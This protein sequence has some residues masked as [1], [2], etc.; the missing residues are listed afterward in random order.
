MEF[1]TGVNK[2]NS[3][4]LRGFSNML[5]PN[6]DNVTINTPHTDVNNVVKPDAF[7]KSLL[8][9]SGG[10]ASTQK[11]KPVI[12]G[13]GVKPVMSG[14]GVKPVPTGNNAIKVDVSE[15]PRK[16]K[17]WKKNNTPILINTPSLRNQQASVKVPRASIKQ[18]KM[19]RTQNTA[20]PRE[21]IH[22]KIKEELAPARKTIMEKSTIGHKIDTTPNVSE[23][24]LMSGLAD[25]KFAQMFLGSST[26]PNVVKTKRVQQNNMTPGYMT[27]SP[28]QAPPQMDNNPM[29]TGV[30]N[31]LKKLNNIL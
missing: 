28:N 8:S 25:N 3:L 1:N 20:A 5:A 24:K 15:S 19:K 21:V 9:T 6:G 16:L 26:R 10:T 2:Q 14:K 31:N 22:R 7:V 23:N 11:I 13:K 30:N 18:I 29:M 17:T 12:S 27:T 4:K